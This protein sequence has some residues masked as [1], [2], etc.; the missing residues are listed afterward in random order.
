MWMVSESVES[1]LRSFMN[2]VFRLS[3]SKISSYGTP[4]ASISLHFCWSDKFSKNWKSSVLKTVICDFW[5][6]IETYF[7]RSFNSDE[8]DGSERENSIFS[9][10]K[11]KNKKDKTNH[12]QYWIQYI[13]K[14]QVS[15]ANTFHQ[16]HQ[17]LCYLVRFLWINYH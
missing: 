1:R 14:A 2:P 4:I 10:E 17:H 5:S 16:N 8:V 3:E 6:N 7:T 12:W 13:D 15:D 9:R 11:K